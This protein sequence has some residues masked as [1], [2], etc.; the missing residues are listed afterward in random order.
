MHVCVSPVVND[1]VHW[2]QCCLY[3]QEFSKHVRHCFESAYPGAQG[4]AKGSSFCKCS[5]WWCLRVCCGF[6]EP[7]C[8]CLFCFS[9]LNLRDLLLYQLKMLME[10]WTLWT[11]SVRFLARKGYNWD[12]RG[13][14]L[15]PV[16]LAELLSWFSP[17]TP[18]EG[19]LFKLR[20][21]FKD[22][23]PSS[24]PKCELLGQMWELWHLPNCINIDIDICLLESHIP[25]I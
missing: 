12:T 16:S 5:S 19:G 11:G 8:N 13:I 22:D 15:L 17:Q 10:H 9:L 2:L 21:L 14:T 6:M 18:W 20:M 1:F 3:F 7:N 24:P 25:T 23:Y 4:V